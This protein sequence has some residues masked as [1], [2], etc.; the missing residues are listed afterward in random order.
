METVEGAELLKMEVDLAYEE[1]HRLAHTLP[2][3]TLQ[4]RREALLSYVRTN[5][6]R[7]VRTLACVRWLVD[8]GHNELIE[9]AKS[10][11]SAAEF[12]RSRINRGQDELYFMHGRLFSCR[13]GQYDVQTAI[14]VLMDGGYPRL[15][16]GIVNSGP[17][18]PMKPLWRVP[19]QGA[20]IARLLERAMKVE[21]LCRERLP[22]DLTERTFAGGC[23]C[24]TSPGRYTMKVTMEG[25]EPGSRW[26]LTQFNLLVAAA[27]G[28]L[29]AVPPMD[30]R[31]KSYLLSLGQM[32]I[33]RIRP[34]VDEPAAGQ[35][36]GGSL[37]AAHAV[38]HE[39]TVATQLEL[40]S[41]QA[42]KLA[43]LHEAASWYGSISVVY[44]REAKVLD[45]LLWGAEFA[46]GVQGTG[47]YAAAEGGVATPPSVNGVPTPSS[48]R[49]A[50][51]F[52]SGEGASAALS[53]QIG[54]CLEGQTPTLNCPPSLSPSSVSASALVQQAVAAFAVAKAGSMAAELSDL[55]SSFCDTSFAS[56][57]VEGP[58]VTIGLHQGGQMHVEVDTRSGRC[59]V[60]LP[61]REEQYYRCSE[62]LSLAEALNLLNEKEKRRQRLLRTTKDAL[63]LLLVQEVEGVAQTE[64]GM[65]TQ[66]RWGLILG[67]LHSIKPEPGDAAATPSLHRTYLVLDSSYQ[68]GSVPALTGTDGA[69]AAPSGERLMFFLEV[70]SPPLCL[71][72]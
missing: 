72:V 18:M 50:R 35:V 19:P 62:A 71:I 14:D 42:R 44:H 26:V 33:D 60:N 48:G 49:F 28:E 39:F 61:A 59:L 57:R 9:K 10:S 1:L 54:P 4:G 22:E 37:A 5:R 24:L 8:S 16:R 66:R 68:R 13:G 38:F 3:E 21:L 47:G 17:D 29:V 53:I 70:S 6:A 11:L 45:I 55:I 12:L 15:P 46:T 65:E 7:F 36:K 34:A 63:R 31:Q 69:A 23:L 2:R 32:A 67:R 41:A 25:Q 40:L 56:I 30:L 27:A 52:I 43:E 51:A 20:E 64:L 58:H